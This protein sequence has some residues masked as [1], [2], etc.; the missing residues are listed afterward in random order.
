MYNET[1]GLVYST[2]IPNKYFKNMNHQKVLFV[3]MLIML[4][5]CVNKELTKKN[6]E[7]LKEEVASYSLEVIGPIM[8]LT[9]ISCIW[10]NETG[11]WPTIPA[12]LGTKSPFSYF[13]V[14]ED[15][16]NYLAEFGMKTSNLDWS[17]NLAFIEKE[18]KKF[19]NST[20]TAKSRRSSSHISFQQDLAITNINTKAW[21]ELTYI[22]YANAYYE[23]T[24]SLYG[25]LRMLENRRPRLTP[26]EKNQFV[27]FLT[28]VLVQATIC[29][30][31]DTDP[32]DCRMQ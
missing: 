14:L 31:L 32:M 1:P 2:I 20:I 18:E 21:G 4:T 27:S 30:V 25:L 5:A 3:V 26:E 24:S 8:Y 13:K 22:H 17:I 28:A 10:I 16:S 7:K 29:A 12:T 9:H 19:C 6:K 15:G 11:G 23:L